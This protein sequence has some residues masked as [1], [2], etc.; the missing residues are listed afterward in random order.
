MSSARLRIAFIGARGVIGTYS[1]IET[2]YE[3]VG[4]RLV[5][6]G[7]EVTAYCRPYFTPD[8]P[9]HRGIQVR[10]L[11]CL[12]TKH[13]ETMSHS[14]LATFDALRRRFD[15]IQ[16]HAI[17]SSP[18]ALIPRM[19]GQ[20]TLVSVRGLDWKRA[21]WGWFARTFLKL[22]EWTSI[23]CPTQTVVVSK[24]LQRHYLSRHGREPVVIPNAVV[25]A[26]RRPA[27]RIKAHG[28]EKD[29]Y[30]LFMGRLSPEKGIHTL[31]EALRPLESRMR[32]V[33][34]GGT[35][36]SDAYID[37][38]RRSAW[39]DVL[40]L[41]EVDREMVAELLSNCYAFIL[42]STM[43]G[44]SIALLEALSYGACIIATN[45]PENLEVIQDAGLSFPPGDVDKL[46]KHLDRILTDPE[47]ARA[48]RAKAANL[49]RN[50]PD[51]DEIARRT[52]DLYLR[53]THRAS[54]ERPSRTS[55][56]TAKR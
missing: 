26:E 32:L 40:L 39:D 12:R 10:R 43:E 49:A 53:V 55:E 33:L 51:W 20:T 6:R 5:K 1:G 7:H 28:L 31:I 25:P 34:A 29:N 56:I 13:L 36:Y 15:I 41:G 37:E 48:Y 52:E 16:Y 42:P 11:P 22:A 3:E 35:S 30:L 2:Y 17:G 21:K 19:I 4:S 9:E 27:D 46:R 14:V 50:Q 24:T 44:L 8:V 45:I 54:Q 47:V 18:L 38:I 23:R